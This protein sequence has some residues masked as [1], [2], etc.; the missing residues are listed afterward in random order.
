MEIKV[1]EKTGVVVVY[2]EG[3]VDIFNADRIPEVI[4]NLLPKPIL[5][6]LENVRYID[7]STVGALISSYK[8][9]AQIQTPFAICSVSRQFTEILEITHIEE[10]F[11][12]YPTE[13][14]GVAE[15]LK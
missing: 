12:L 7:S 9:A 15:L 1:K 13:E 3:T 10:L 14:E 5:I 2:I 6:N 11:P 4:A 8:K